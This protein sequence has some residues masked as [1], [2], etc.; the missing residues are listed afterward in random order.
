[1]ARVVHFEIHAKDAA[2]A[3]RF[4]SG[5]FGWTFSKWEG[6]HDYWVIKTGEAD[7]EGIDGG[8]AIRHGPLPRETQPLNGSVCTL[9]VDKIETTL[10]AVVV[11]G[12]TVSV[13]K[14]PIHHVGWLAYFR[15]TEGNLFGIMEKDPTV[16]KPGIPEFP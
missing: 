11:A 1:M 7:T 9:A 3:M 4:W 15:D 6:P 13:E 8:M 12:G 14:F 5:T 16:V 2:R 10:S